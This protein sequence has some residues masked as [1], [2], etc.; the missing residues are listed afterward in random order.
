MR[1][2]Y[3]FKFV[4]SPGGLSKVFCAW[5]AGRSLKFQSPG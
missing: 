4:P 1:L 2:E 5:Y 3:M